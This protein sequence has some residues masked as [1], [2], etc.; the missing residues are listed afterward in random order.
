MY[1]SLYIC[2]M[3]V[4]KLKCPKKTVIKIHMA[5]YGREEGGRICPSS[6]SLTSK[7]RLR[8]DDILVDETRDVMEILDKKCSDKK[9]CK[10]KPSTKLFGDPC[11]QIY[12]YLSLVYSCGKK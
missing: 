12:K 11:P 8:E 6:T 1:K 9:S 10:I 4:G 3:V 7:C 5:E 2:D